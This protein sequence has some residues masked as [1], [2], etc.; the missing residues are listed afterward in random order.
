MARFDPRSDDAADAAGDGPRR[1]AMD[2]AGYLLQAR[3]RSEAE[4]RQRL[5]DKG[6]PPADIDDAVNRLKRLGFVDDERFAAAYVRDGANLKRRGRY[7]LRQELHQRGV[8]AELIDRVLDAEFPATDEASLGDDLAAKRAE[9]LRDEP[10]EVGRRRLAGFL[11]RRGLPVG[12]VREL[13]DRY[14][15][16][17]AADDDEAGGPLA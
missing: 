7:R 13:V 8:S 11:S 2:D 16:W 3:L 6:H 9:R 15:P 12:L 4:L 14:L 1:S 17:D 10:R 5:R